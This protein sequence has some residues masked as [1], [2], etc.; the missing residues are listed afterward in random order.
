MISLVQLVSDHGQPLA[1]TEVK[2]VKHRPRII[3]PQVL[4]VSLI[5][6]LF[7][8]PYFATQAYI[9]TYVADLHTPV[10]VGSFFPI[11][12]V[13]LLG[14]RLALKNLFDSVAFGRF[15]YASLGF[16]MV[17]L[18]ALTHLVNNW[19]MLLAAFGLA[20]GYGLMFSICQAT[21]LLIAPMSQQGLANSTFYIGMDLG[22]ALGPIIGGLIRSALPVMWFYP[23]MMIT[24]PLI[25]AVYFFNRRT[26][27]HVLS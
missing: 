10:A 6:M 22:M 17:G 1:K 16:T 18:L 7:A 5:I 15:L 12:A 13:I 20:A 3:Q 24:L 8:L 27:D 14:L 25:W 26:L 19:W 21:A 23:V 2:V 11:Y 9:V 4:P